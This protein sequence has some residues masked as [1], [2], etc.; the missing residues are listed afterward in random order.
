MTGAAKPVTIPRERKKVPTANGVEA[1][2]ALGFHASI[3]LDWG[4][5]GAQK[6]EVVIKSA[7]RAT[8]MI[9]EATTPAVTEDLA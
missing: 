2:S 9:T 5:L 4:A 3:L 1:F 7:P 8:P 6:Q